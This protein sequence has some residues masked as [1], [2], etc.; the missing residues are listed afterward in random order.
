MNSTMVLESYGV[1][2]LGDDAMSQIDG[3]LAGWGKLAEWVAIYF[4]EN[5]GDFVK[6]VSEGW[7]HGR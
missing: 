6:G 3:G 5:A 2:A 1:Q 7:N 4:A